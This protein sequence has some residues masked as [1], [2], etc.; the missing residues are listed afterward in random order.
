LVF[1]KPIDKDLLIELSKTTKTWFIF[2]DS[3][4]MGGVASAIL[5]ALAELNIDNIQ[6]VSFEY[7]KVKLLNQV[8]IVFTVS[9]E[10][11][12]GKN[13]WLDKARIMVPI[14]S[15]DFKYEHPVNF[16]NYEYCFIA[17]YDLDGTK[18]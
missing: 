3:A 6:V 8:V 18:R 15:L 12:F 9:N 16:C 7:E 13:G 11:R 10:K 17:Q 14:K 1:V 2:S 4:K 5:E